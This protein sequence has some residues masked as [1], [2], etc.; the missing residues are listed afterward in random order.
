MVVRGPKG[1]RHGAEARVTVRVRIR[2]GVGVRVRVRVRVRGQRKGAKARGRAGLRAT[3]HGLGW[4]RGRYLPVVRRQGRHVIRPCVSRAGAG[5]AGDGARL[6]DHGEATQ[7]LS[8]GLR[9]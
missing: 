3:V 8:A 7:A 1:W 4:V 5:V 6:R 2:V 9:A